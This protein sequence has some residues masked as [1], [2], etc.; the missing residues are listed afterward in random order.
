VK[1]NRLAVDDSR[2]NT[3]RGALVQLSNPSSRA[4]YYL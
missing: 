1:T 2:L 4:I 3:K